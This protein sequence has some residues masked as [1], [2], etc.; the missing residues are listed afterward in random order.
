MVSTEEFNTAT[1]E[2]R[3]ELQNNVDIISTKQDSLE[4]EINNIKEDALFDS[5]GSM[6]SEEVENDL[7]D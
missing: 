5:K 4:Q 6:S 7:K 2:L 3:N 1:T